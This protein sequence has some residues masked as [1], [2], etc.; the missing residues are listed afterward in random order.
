LAD[1]KRRHSK[2]GLRLESTRLGVRRSGALILKIFRTFF[3]VLGLRTRRWWPGTPTGF[4]PPGI[5]PLYQLMGCGWGV[6]MCHAGAGG[7][8]K[9]PVPGPACASSR[10]SRA[11]LAQQLQL[12]AHTSQVLVYPLGGTSYWGHPLGE[13]N[14]PPCGGV[15]FGKPARGRGASTT[16]FLSPR[17]CF[18]RLAPAGRGASTAEKLDPL[19]RRSG[20]FAPRDLHV[21]LAKHSTPGSKK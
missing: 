14:G 7:L 11:P 4:T 20:I 10:T 2:L 1:F 13:P 6:G 8:T 12:P 21:V 17:S 9:S 19:E 16:G 18:A 5:P 15:G 3:C